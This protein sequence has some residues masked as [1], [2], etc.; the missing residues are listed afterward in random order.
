MDTQKAG[1][2]RVVCYSCKKVIRV[3][4]TCPSSTSDRFVS[5]LNMADTPTSAAS[6]HESY[7]DPHSTETEALVSRV[8]Q[9]NTTSAKRIALGAIGLL[10]VVG[11]LVVVLIVNVNN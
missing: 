3:I 5:D 8:D 10:L 7:T 4:R 11:I 9:R 2:F 1:F 6:Q